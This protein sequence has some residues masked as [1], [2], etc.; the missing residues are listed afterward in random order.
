[1]QPRQPLPHS[2]TCS[3]RLSKCAPCSAR[4]NSKLSPQVTLCGSS[5][6]MKCSATPNRLQ[7]HRRDGQS[8]SAAADAHCW[9]AALHIDL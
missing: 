7:P 6:V 5:L 8:G 3:C 4:T 1:M 2:D 9:G